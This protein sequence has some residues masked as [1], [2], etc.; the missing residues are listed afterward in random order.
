MLLKEITIYKD[1]VML[2]KVFKEGGI[3]LIYGES[4]T[5]K[6]VSTIKALNE[7]DIIPILLDYDGN[8][9]PKDNECEYI[10]ID[11]VKYLK[12]IESTIPT[13]KVI[14]IDT[15]QMLITNGGGIKTIEAI[16]EAG[17][18][19]I[20][21][22]HNKA[23]ATKQDIPDIDPRYSNHFSSKLFIE[24]DKGSKTKTN[25]RAPS[26]NLIV[27][28]LRGYKGDRVLYNWMRD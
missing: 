24:F 22:A 17:N 18:T 6:T 15:W 4:G 5:G 20:L 3:N 2:G 11:G 27:L 28:K 26:Y 10:H 14:V 25:T 13:G 23:I 12:D 1:R 9:S 7:E 21:I 19:V 16:C 8:D